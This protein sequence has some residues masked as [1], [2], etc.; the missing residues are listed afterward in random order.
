V[1]RLI[2]DVRPGGVILFAYNIKSPDQVRDLI[3]SLHE[4]AAVPLFIATDQ[5]G[6][7]VRRVVPSPLMPA[8]EVPAAELVGSAGDLALT[9][10]LSRVIGTELRALGITM[11]FAPVADIAT[12]QHNTVIA[13]RAFGSDPVFV[14]EMVAASVRGLQAANV[15]AVLKHFP[16]HGDTTADSH[17]ASP[18]VPHDLKRLSEVELVP[19]RSGLRAGADAVMIGHLR[20][21]EIGRTDLPA[22]IDPAVVNGLLRGRMGFQG[23]VVTDALT[24]AAVAEH[25][26]EPELVVRAVAAGAD[27]LLAPADPRGAVQ[28]LTA[29][30]RS[31]RIAESRIDASVTR[32]LE[33]K[34]RRGILAIAPDG[35]PAVGSELIPD[36]AVHEVMG[37]AAHQ[38]IV[39]QIKVQAG[40]E[41]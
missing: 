23:L 22:T 28:A 40:S 38:R 37:T 11:N 16:G 18:V 1:L 17:T 3:S 41:Q 10:A 20:V 7:L 34:R 12:N 13:G 19:F 26:S 39:D 2:R 4:S 31:G 14:S 35:T 27:V 9:E 32:I 33:V 15:S 21:A 29:A 30:V 8:T 6:G 5:E 24:M 25:Y 36:T